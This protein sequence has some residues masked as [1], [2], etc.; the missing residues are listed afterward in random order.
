MPEP[1]GELGVAD[2]LGLARRLEREAEAEHEPAVGVALEDARAVVEEALLGV[3]RVDLAARAVERADRDD[4][5]GDLLA[6]GA[7]VL[8]RRRPGAAGDP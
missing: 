7:D 1:R 4:R 3:E 8:D 5:V 2:R 6:V